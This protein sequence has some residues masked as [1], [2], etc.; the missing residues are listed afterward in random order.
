MLQKVNF[1][2]LKLR[3]VGQAILQLTAVISERYFVHVSCLANFGLSSCELDSL[4]TLYISTAATPRGFF[5]C[6]NF[7]DFR[8]G[9]LFR[10][11][12]FTRFSLVLASLCFESHVTSPADSVLQGYAPKSEF[13]CFETSPSW[14]CHLYTSHAT[15]DTSL[16]TR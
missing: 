5:P 14:P 15:H 12:F 10:F 9:F 3:R 7:P 6:H 8:R 11:G 1:T 13:H 16:R 2:G 4:A